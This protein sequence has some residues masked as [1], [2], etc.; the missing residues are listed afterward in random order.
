[1]L[2]MFVPA[3]SPVFSND[4]YFLSTIPIVV[5]WSHGSGGGLSNRN[6]SFLALRA[7]CLGR[8]FLQPTCGSADGTLAGSISS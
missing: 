7:A 4:F 8:S 5:H 6:I 1:M 3:F 2:S